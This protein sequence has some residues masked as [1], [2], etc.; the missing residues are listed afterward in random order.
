MRHA[1]LAAT[2]IVICVM[3][4]GPA[5]AQS[6]RQK[7]LLDQMLQLLPKSEPW[8]QWLR[9]SRELP[10]D[11]EALPAQFFLPDPLRLSD[12]DMV[13]LNDWP[14]HRHELLNLFQYYVIG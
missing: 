11:F 8:E 7:A 13:G 6:A 2:V 3:C 9:K 1:L 10:P 12:G 5:F 4:R 14:R